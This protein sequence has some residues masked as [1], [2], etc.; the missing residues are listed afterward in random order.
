MFATIQEVREE[1]EKMIEQ[2]GV[3]CINKDRMYCEKCES[4][5]YILMKLKKEIFGGE[6]N[7]K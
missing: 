7:E 6:N 4:Q 3:K 1:I 2:V 5:K